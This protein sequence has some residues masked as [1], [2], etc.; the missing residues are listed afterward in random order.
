[1]RIL[2]SF[3][4]TFEPLLNNFSF[5]KDKVLPPKPSLHFIKLFWSNQLNLPS[6]PPSSHSFTIQQAEEGVGRCGRAGV[7]ERLRGE[8]GGHGAAVRPPD[9]PQCQRRRFRGERNMLVL[10]IQGGPSGFHYLV[11]ISRQKFR[12]SIYSLH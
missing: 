7:G 2:I 12:H 4:S 10:S 6:K 8:G 9:E 1:M 3:R 11:L 5:T